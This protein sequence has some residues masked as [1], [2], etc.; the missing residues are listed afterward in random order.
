M[1][2]SEISYQ[3][4]SYG[5]DNF[6][7]RGE[8][9]WDNLTKYEHHTT[10]INRFPRLKTI[11]FFILKIFFSLL[12]HE[13]SSELRAKNPH[14]FLKNWDWSIKNFILHHIRIFRST[15][16]GLPAPT[17]F[18]GRLVQGHSKKFP[19]SVGFDPEVGQ[20]FL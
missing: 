17:T 8:C 3:K 5:A 14:I 7:F 4:S 20:R 19:R 11:E 13:K 9:V 18:L 2:K 1:K 10:I 15:E 12:N 16:T 6:R